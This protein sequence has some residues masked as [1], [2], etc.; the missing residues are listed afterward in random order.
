[1]STA[2]KRWSRALQPLDPLLMNLGD[3]QQAG[4]SFHDLRH[5]AI[6]LAILRY[7]QLHGL[8]EGLMP[9]REAL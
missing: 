5:T 3:M 2:A 7:H 8:G 9:L 1:M 4:D 6:P